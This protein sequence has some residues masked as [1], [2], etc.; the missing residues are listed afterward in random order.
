MS[1]S[2][3]STSTLVDPS[4]L[5]ATQTIRTTEI[6]RLADLQNHCFALCGTHNILS[7]T[8]DDSCFV[9]DSTSFV[10][11]SKWYIPMISQ[12][13]DELKIRVSAF[14]ATA[15]AQVRFTLSFAFSV[16]TYTDTVTITD[17]GRYSSAFNVATISITNTE[18]EQFAILTMEAKA[19]A[20]D[21]IEVLGVQANWSAIS[22]P[23]SAG[24]HYIATSEF[25]PV[26][27]NRQGADLPLSSRF[28]VQALSNIA[29]LRKR[30]R[31]LLC[32]SGV[33]NASSASPLSDAANPPI[34]LGYGDQLNMTSVVALPAGMNEIDGLSISL[35]LFAVGI[36]GSDTIVLEIF[37]HRITVSSNGWNS[38]NL[39][40]VG[41]DLSISNELDMSMFR[42]G[43]HTSDTN[44]RNLLGTNNTIASNPYI[45][46][47]SIIGV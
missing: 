30:G 12:S 16:N 15:G 36:S 39:Q 45:S 33:S 18:T 8:Y 35:F 42:V 32:W 23:L 3:T 19:P 37:N 20:S 10:E 17:N 47:I 1:N 4:R 34:G 31:V 9:Q 13:H 38:F 26:G 25:I 44:A 28:G 29:T 7:Q 24:K 14:C 43:I 11:M 6:A 22:S 5:T 41:D 27:Q 40:I 21:E 46:S 2:F